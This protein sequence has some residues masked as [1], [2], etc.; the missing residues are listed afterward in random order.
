MVEATP[1]RNNPENKEFGGAYVNCWVKA[2]TK[3][4]ALS[5]VKKY[6]DEENW[7]FVKTKDIF[8]AQR[9]LYLDEPDSL[10][11]YDEAC[12]KGL[13]AIFYTWPI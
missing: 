3:N 11:C 9:H 1:N 6:I 8:I 12:K 4:H 10:E 5:I 13:S 7:L 2:T